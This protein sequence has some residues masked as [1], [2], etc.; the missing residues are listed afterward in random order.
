MTA[1]PRGATPPA[2]LLGGTGSP[3][4]RC[5][6][7][8]SPVLLSGDVRRPSQMSAPPVTAPAPL[9][10]PYCWWHHP[11]SADSTPHTDI[12]C[13][14]QPR[15]RHVTCPYYHV[16]PS[17]TFAR[18]DALVP[19]SQLTWE[20]DNSNGGGGPVAAPPVAVLL[21]PPVAVHRRPCSSGASAPRPP[22]CC[23]GWHHPMS[24]GRT[25]RHRHA[26]LRTHGSGHRCPLSTVPS[27]RPTLSLHPL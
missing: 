10:P 23:C 5:A 4:V 16:M 2:P 11:P 19:R 9:R 12:S 1:T 6:S 20:A 7:L 25:P 21:P 24:A 22:C 17:V 8:A 14:F 3:E 13:C 26:T 18:C 15:H 27:S